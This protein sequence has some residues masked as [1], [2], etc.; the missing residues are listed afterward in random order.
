MKRLCYRWSLIV[1]LV[2]WLVPGVSQARIKLVA[3][4]D[5]GETTIRLDNPRATLIEEE[6]VL[7]LQAGR[8]QVDFS[9]RGVSIDADSIRLSLLDA[10]QQVQLLNVSYPPN[11]AALVW[12]ISCAAA[13]EAPVRI[14]YLLGNIDGVITYQAIANKAETTVD[15]KSHLVLRN[16]SGEDFANAHVLLDYGDAFERGLAHEETKQLLFLKRK[17]I[18]IE[19]V[20]TFDAA[21]HIWDPEQVQDNVGIPVHYK[22]KNSQD[23]GLGEFA[24][25]GGKFRVQQDDG[26][27]GTIVLGEDVVGLVPVGEEMEVAI[28]DSRDI[29]VTQRKQYEKQI[30]YR[31]NNKNRVV[32]YDTDELLTAKIENFKDTPATLTM[33][34]HIPGEWDMASCNHKYERKDSETL[35]FKIQLAAG[36]TENLTM[37]YHRRNLR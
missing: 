32:L 35:E 23:R 19:K 6:R 10:S 15:L 13:V 8:N 30:N 18:P 14:S 4:P 26:H 7:T 34:Q 17:R 1:T 5:R 25:K 16:F 28:G 2:C 27:D 21:E 36:E 31:R 24:L 11:E 20:W 22:I 37:H 29:V 9:W 12:E 3:L 33:V